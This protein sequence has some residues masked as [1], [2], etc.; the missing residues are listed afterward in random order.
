MAKG[1]LLSV[2][3]IVIWSAAYIIVVHARRP[4]GKLT[5]LTGLFAVTIPLY[6]LLHA[7]TPPDLGVL[8]AA[9]A[10]TPSRLG[11]VNGLVIH[12]L[13]Y[14]TWMQGFYYVD[15]SVTLRLLVELVK[16]PGGRLALADVR[17]I[18]GLAQMID[19]RM[20][21]LVESGYV[22]ETDGRFVL[23][24]KGRVL[25]TGVRLLRRVLGARYY[26]AVDD[27]P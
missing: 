18:Y 22:E 14:C 3:L 1:I 2:T 11:L 20:K 10:A 15:R 13:L 17:A 24:P 27:G 12:L 4:A 16:A 9:Y 25:D 19:R 21:S 7:V 23:T 26:F 6:L 8:P 5:V